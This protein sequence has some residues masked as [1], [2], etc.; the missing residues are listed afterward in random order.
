[1]F[2]VLKNG[3]CGFERDKVNVFEDYI[4]A[5]GI[6]GFDRYC[7]KFVR[8]YKSKEMGL[9]VINEVREDFAALFQNFTV[10]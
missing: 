6:N 1:M 8:A 2:R 4:L 5:F 9:D 7:E 10:T 3:L